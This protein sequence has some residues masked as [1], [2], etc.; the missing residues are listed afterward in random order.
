[1]STNNNNPN[2]VPHPNNN[3]TINTRLSYIPQR[4][5]SNSASNVRFNPLHSAITNLI[6]IQNNHNI[7]QTTIQPPILLSDRD[8]LQQ[9]ISQSKNKSI[10]LIRLNITYKAQ[11]PSD[12]PKILIDVPFDFNLYQ[13]HDIIQCLFQFNNARLHK[14]ALTINGEELTFMLPDIHNNYNWRTDLHCDGYH[15]AE[16][17]HPHCLSEYTYMNQRELTCK[18]IFDERA[19]SIFDALCC[20]DE[21]EC[22]VLEYEYD[23]GACHEMFIVAN[24]IRTI[25]N[26]TQL[27]FPLIIDANN[28]IYYGENGNTVKRFNTSLAEQKLELK[29]RNKWPLELTQQNRVARHCYICISN[30][31]CRNRTQCSGN[32][33]EQCIKRVNVR[34]DIDLNAL[35]LQYVQKKQQLEMHHQRKINQQMCNYIEPNGLH[36]CLC[37][38]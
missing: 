21:K 8:R 16:H 34:N 7:N 4:G 32:C 19:I 35:Y 38:H 11:N 9:Q 30:R 29:F 28:G 31:M 33:C 20:N 22:K 1:M 25:L 12:N 13:I 18:W 24:E 36:C 26:P 37:N 15:W 3:T 2:N 27:Q 10:K 17:S 14:F 5:Q 23:F 6:N